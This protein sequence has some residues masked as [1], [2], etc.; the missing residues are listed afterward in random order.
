MVWV[1]LSE[2]MTG[3][4]GVGLIGECVCVNRCFSGL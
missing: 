3:V 4:Q 1:E 2:V